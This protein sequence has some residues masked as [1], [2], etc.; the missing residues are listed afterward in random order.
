MARRGGV[1]L[2]PYET[3]DTLAR[4]AAEIAA[5]EPAR[6][7]C[8][9]DSFDDGAAAAALGP[10][11]AAR[12]AALG[13]GRHWL[14]IAGNHDPAPPGLPG[15]WA[16]EAAI[17]PLALRHVARAERPPE[18]RAE[19]SAHYHPK[20]RL[21][22]R[23]RR[24]ARPCLLADAR[25]AILPAFGTYTGGLDATD[26]AFD[27]LL[28]GDARAWLTGRRVVGLPRAGLAR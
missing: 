26:P 13:R 8:L 5:L 28:A 1:L 6:V 3:E 18:S 22:H 20:A 10:A 27:R 15:D 2:P 9:G 14:W 11:L 23:G 19:L 25:R 24:I 17:G 7:V 12:R 4:L 21:A 16:S